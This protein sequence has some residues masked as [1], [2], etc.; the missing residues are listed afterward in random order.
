ME[1]CHLGPDVPSSDV[2][3]LPLTADSIF[4]TSDTPI[5]P[6]SPISSAVVDVMGVRCSAPT[7]GY[8]VALRGVSKEFQRREKQGLRMFFAV[9]KL[10]ME[11]ATT[12]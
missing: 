3:T 2:K 12:K 10:A 1:E 4:C 9:C 5:S 6:R 7:T 8:L 11:E